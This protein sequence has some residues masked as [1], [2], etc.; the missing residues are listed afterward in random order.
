MIKNPSRIDLIDVENGKFYRSD[1]QR[2]KLNEHIMFVGRGWYDYE[3]AT[4]LRQYD[5]LGFTYDID[6]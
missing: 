2:G 1:V 3:K 5:V 4:K 6:A